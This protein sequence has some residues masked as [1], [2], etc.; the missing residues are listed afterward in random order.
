VNLVYRGHFSTTSTTSLRTASTCVCV[1]VWVGGGC[2]ESGMC[3]RLD[4]SSDT[5]RS[6]LLYLVLC[7][8]DNH[9]QARSRS[10]SW[11]GRNQKQQSKLS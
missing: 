2:N 11:S 10:S 5:W 7:V 8:C 4:Y 9:K 3:G 1:C 6:Y